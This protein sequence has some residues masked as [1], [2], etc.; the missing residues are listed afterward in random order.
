MGLVLRAITLPERILSST[1]RHS[2]LKLICLDF[3]DNDDISLTSTCH[4]KVAENL[5]SACVC[6][7]VSGFG[8][9]ISFCF[10]IWSRI[11]RRSWLRRMKDRISLKRQSVSLLFWL[12]MKSSVQDF[13]ERLADTFRLWGIF[14]CCWSCTRAE[15]ETWDYWHLWGWFEIFA[16]FGVAQQNFLS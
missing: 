16:A 14:C 3:D 1:S 4:L 10:A 12:S 8:F 7:F 5:F 6:D 9:T 15:R 13:S 11:G 2:Y